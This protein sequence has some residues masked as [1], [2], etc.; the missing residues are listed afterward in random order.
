MGRR[1]PSGKPPKKTAPPLRLDLGAGRTKEAGW[2][3]VDVLPEFKPDVVCDLGF[4]E[5]PWKDNSVEEARASHFVEHL[6]AIQRIHFANELWRVLKPGAKATIITPH[7]FS[8]RA[9]GDLTHQWPPVTMWWYFYLNKTWREREAPHSVDYVCNFDN[10][11]G[12]SVPPHW[13]ARNVETQTFA[14]QNYVEGA[15]DLIATIT[16]LV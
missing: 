12:F 14:M 4:E 5:W 11:W 15:S 1:K 16:K 6:T 10:G 13:A 2:T 7:A 8:A 9:Y 3:S